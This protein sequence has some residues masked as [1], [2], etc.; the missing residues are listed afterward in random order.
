MPEFPLVTRSRKLSRSYQV[1]QAGLLPMAAIMAAT[2][3]PAEMLG[4]DNEIGT[5]EVGKRADLVIV[6]DDPLSDLGA[7]R[8][9]AWTIKDGTVH[10]PEEWMQQ[11]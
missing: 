11:R 4:L 5:V 6:H 8:T 1:G 3:V 10:T 7:L 2:R 9:V